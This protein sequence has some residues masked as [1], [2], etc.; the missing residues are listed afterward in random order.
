[1]DLGGNTPGEEAFNHSQLHIRDGFI[2]LTD[3]NLDGSL[4]YAPGL[5]DILAIINNSSSDPNST[6]GMFS[7]G[8]SVD[9]TFGADIYRFDITYEADV[10]VDGTPQH[11]NVKRHSIAFVESWPA[12]WSPS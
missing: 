12:V 3:S 2:D 8:S 4:S 10:K 6:I 5:N 11:S 1:M 9:I 7:Q